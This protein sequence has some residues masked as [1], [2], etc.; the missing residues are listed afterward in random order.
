MNDI[1]DKATRS[2][3]MAG[4]LAK[5][6]RPERALRRALHGRGFRFRL[7]VPESPRKAR[8]YPASPRCRLLCSR[9]FLAPPCRVPL[10]NHASHQAQPLGGQVQEQRRAGLPFEEPTSRCR[11]ASRYRVGVRP[12]QGQACGDGPRFGAM[13]SY[14]H[15]RIRDST[16]QAVGHPC[17]PCGGNGRTPAGG[18]HPN[19]DR[20]IGPLS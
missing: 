19:A 3:M 15:P 14:E 12:P 16:P 2:R 18:A 20:Q 11:L 4:I 7:H 17:A 6:T 8:S 1:V 10:C 5:D 13:A 9:L